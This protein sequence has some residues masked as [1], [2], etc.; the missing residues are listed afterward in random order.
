M[1][2]VFSYLYDDGIIFAQG[3][4]KD[5]EKEIY[6]TAEIRKEEGLGKFEEYLY[7]IENGV[8]TIT[9]TK[10]KYYKK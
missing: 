10:D 8:S 1:V 4:K 9:I 6:F 7:I 3:G 2:H 5:N